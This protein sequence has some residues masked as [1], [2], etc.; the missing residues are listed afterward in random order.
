MWVCGP[1]QHAE[2]TVYRP[3]IPTTVPHRFTDWPTDTDGLMCLYVADPI[4]M[5][6]E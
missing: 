4:R 5:L 6:P 3:I 1:V 2:F